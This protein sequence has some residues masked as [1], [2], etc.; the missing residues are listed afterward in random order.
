MRGDA[1]EDTLMLN[2]SAVKFDLRNLEDLDLRGIGVNNLNGSGANTLM[3]DAR[4]LLDISDHN[5]VR[6]MG[7]ADDSRNSPTDVVIRNETGAVDID[8]QHYDRC[9]FGDAILLMHSDIALNN[10]ASPHFSH[11][12]LAP[13]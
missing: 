5:V 8:G 3:L 11:P 1:G 2:G 12:Y 7:G 4:D 13:R 10:V 6:V 9:D